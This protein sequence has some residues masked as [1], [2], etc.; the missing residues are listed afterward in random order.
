MLTP[1]YVP[2]EMWALDAQAKEAGLVFLNELGLDPGIDHLSAMRI[3]DR[4]RAEGASLEAFESYTG[5]LVA[6]ESDD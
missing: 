5:G 2:K 6:P 1:S 4:L 3:L